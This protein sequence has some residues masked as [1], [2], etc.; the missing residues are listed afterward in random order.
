MLLLCLGVSS[1]ITVHLRSGY[2]PWGGLTNKGNLTKRGSK[3]SA[4]LKRK[5]LLWSR[6]QQG[7]A[8]LN[9]LNFPRIASRE[10]HVQILRPHQTSRLLL[11]IDYGQTGFERRGLQLS[12]RGDERELPGVGIKLLLQ[13]QS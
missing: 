12:I 3:A 6:P 8:L 2:L 1:G 10:P 9:S 13:H 5:V 4:S 11:R 7:N